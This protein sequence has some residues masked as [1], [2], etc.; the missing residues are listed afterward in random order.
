M[1]NPFEQEKNLCRAQPPSFQWELVQK[2]VNPLRMQR[3][4]LVSNVRL[5][6]SF[7][8]H[9]DDN[10]A[11]ALPAHLKCLIRTHV[12]SCAMKGS[13]PSFYKLQWVPPHFDSFRAS[14]ASIASRE[15]VRVS[16]DWEAALVTVNPA[17]QRTLDILRPV[18]L[19]G[20]SVAG[21]CTEATADAS[22]GELGDSAPSSAD[23]DRF[24]VGDSEL[25]A[26]ASAAETL[27][28]AGTAGG[29]EGSVPFSVTVGQGV[30]DGHF[31]DPRP[32]RMPRADMEADDD[33][34][35][36]GSPLPLQLASG[37]QPPEHAVPAADTLPRG[38]TVISFAAASA[39]EVV[40]AAV[41]DRAVAASDTPSREVAVPK[42]SALAAATALAAAPA[43]PLSLP[44]TAGTAVA[45]SAGSPLPANRASP[46]LPPVP[47][48]S[49]V[50][51]AR[52]VK[53]SSGKG[54]KELSGAK[55]T[56]NASK[57]GSS[58][59]PP[60]P[61]MIAAKLAK[62]VEAAKKFVL[63]DP[64]NKGK[65]VPF[66]VQEVAPNKYWEHGGVLLTVIFPFLTDPSYQQR[67]KMVVLCDKTRGMLD[68]SEMGLECEDGEGVE[69]RNED[70]EMVALN[71]KTD[72]EVNDASGGMG[73]C[74]AAVDDADS[75]RA[76]ISGSDKAVFATGDAAGASQ[77]VGR[78]KGVNKSK[79]TGGGTYT[80]IVGFEDAVVQHDNGACE[81]RTAVT[82]SASDDG[83]NDVN[84]ALAKFQDACD[85]TR[86]QFMTGLGEELGGPSCGLRVRTLQCS[87]P[88]EF[89]LRTS[90]FTKLNLDLSKRFRLPWCAGVTAGWPAL[91]PLREEGMVVSL[92]SSVMPE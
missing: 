54:R 64:L 90:F 42:H 37:K 15:L 57:G 4:Q 81:L 87:E 23:E 79:M 38:T 26:A 25:A 91:P 43:S 18:L 58:R 78:K 31:D 40:P 19:S 66:C 45:A 61:A 56:S 83:T 5:R 47:P 21:P 82:Q 86:N 71:C 73:G 46:G 28:L 33:P 68:K 75:E 67:G 16:I 74:P 13:L 80:I 36:R 10:Q 69:R 63:S 53:A 89:S 27:A 2:L 8:V 84:H 51:V 24:P 30:E 62:E 59:T 7:C 49:K 76:A 50:G 65:R 60:S 70:T 41:S 17:V 55:R 29:A 22:D 77:A 3:G 52:R 32:P 34:L 88:S 14:S 92:S 9:G 85:V 44:L 39:D 48:P 6:D 20:P 72:D 35:G 1:Q 11:D 12:K